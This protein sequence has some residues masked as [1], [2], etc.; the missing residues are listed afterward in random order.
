V[1]AFTFTALD[2]LG[3]EQKGVMEADS[4]R[5]VR[6]LLRDQGLSPLQILPAARQD[7]Y[8]K[9]SFTLFDSR[10]LKTAELALF[11]RQLAT[12]LQ[13][14]LPLEQ[15]L[16]AIAKQAEQEK[17]SS[18]I[19]GVR[20]KVLEGFT[21]ARA[22]AEYPKAFPLLYRATVASGEHAGHIDGVLERLADHTEN[23]HAAKQKVMLAM[24]YPALL[25][26][27]AVTIVLGL[28][29]FVVP[30]VI[31]VFSD[32]GQQLPLMTRIL[33]G[34]SDLLSNHGGKLFLALVMIV[35]GF[36][37]LLNQSAFRMQWDRRLLRVPLLGKLL[38][39]I[40]TARIA[41]TLHIL[42]ASGVPLVEAMKIS[43]DVLGNNWLKAQ[44]QKITQQVQEG[45]SLFRALEHSGSFPPMM[46]H[47]IASGEHSGELGTMLGRIA[48]HQQR[49]LDTK[50]SAMIGIL[51]PLMLLFM[52]GTVLFIVLAILLPILNMNTLLSN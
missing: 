29:I 21:L 6:Q 47:M 35:S 45:S 18:I 9:R 52:G 1:A 43:T 3:S 38:L 37:Y 4:S 22:M 8:A 14:G 51:E 44:M 7:Q 27:T 34:F 2:T 41:G 26:L 11:T 39:G 33:V 17:V 19:M 48:T 25:L 40:D 42:N 20:S 16:G 30:G 28:M 36:R 24:L 46:V 23:E 12:L 15:S 31:E 10:G 50:I 13:S 49:E 32:Q 5:Q